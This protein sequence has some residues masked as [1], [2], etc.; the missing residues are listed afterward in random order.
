MHIRRGREREREPSLYRASCSIASHWAINQSGKR[1]KEIILHDNRLI[2]SV[3]NQHLL[4][5]HSLIILS[6][7]LLLSLMCSRCLTHTLAVVLRRSS[8]R[9]DLRQASC[10]SVAAAVATPSVTQDCPRLC[11]VGQASAG[12]EM[13]ACASA[14]MGKLSARRS[15]RCR[16]RAKSREQRGCRSDRRAQD[17]ARDSRALSLSRPSLSSLASRRQMDHF[18]FLTYT[19]TLDFHV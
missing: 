15:I 5:S 19:I 14:A 9:N 1:E 16:G 11:T 18:S 10:T 13:R 4:L 2:M 17:A 12:R 8:D 3:L 6:F 7:V